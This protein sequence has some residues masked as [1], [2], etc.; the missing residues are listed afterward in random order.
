MLAGVATA[1]AAQALYRVRVGHCHQLG[2]IAA[3]GHVQLYLG[4]AGLG[5]RF[6]Q[7]LGIRRQSV[8]SNRFRDSLA[9]QI[10]LGQEF[11]P[12]SINVGGV[13][14]H[15]LP[16]VGQ[17]TV[18]VAQHSG[19][20]G[21]RGARQG[22]DIHLGVSIHHD[23]LAGGHALNG[24]NLVAQ[25]GGGLE[26]Q[27]IGGGFHLLPQLLDDILFAVADHSQRPLHGIVVGLASNLAAANG[28]ALADVGI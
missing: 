8:D 25:Q 22:D 15:E 14:E 23:F 1:L 16:L 5:Q 27:T 24:L 10:I 19:A 18:A 28:H 6:V 21:P 17:S 26:V 3:L 11:L 4:A 13:V 9:V 7:R 12:Y 20:D 2:Y